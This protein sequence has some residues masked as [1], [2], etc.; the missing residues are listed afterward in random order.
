[1]LRSFAEGRL[2]GA[3]VGTG[4]PRVL[5]LH[6]WGRSHHDF[7]AVLAPAGGGPPFA[8]IALDLPGFG[9]TPPPPAAWGAGD[10]ARAVAP[11]LDDM[12]PPVVVLG[13]SFGGRVAVH[14]AAGFPDQVGALVV[15][16]APLLPAPRRRP[17]PVPAFRLTRRLHRLHLVSDARM[18]RA[19]R[20]YG[21]ADYRAA[22]GVMRDVLVRAVGERDD[23]QLAQLRCPTTLVWGDDDS[24]APLAVART[25]AATVADCR[26]V[27]C[28]G[29]GHLTPLTA[30][31]A[32]RDAVRRALEEQ[33]APR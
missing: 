13:H 8:A 32:L 15:S 11:V 7:D 27:V 23:E 22:R 10:F 31:E 33:V 1:V 16:G 21:S 28:P 2:F 18:E 14:L 9:A 12:E 6:G 26:L 19:R 20:R 29:A 17:R 5:A 4:R 24:A 25:V 3:A 30:P